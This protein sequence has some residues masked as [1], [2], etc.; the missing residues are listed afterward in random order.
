[1]QYSSNQSQVWYARTEDGWIIIPNAK[2]VKLVGY[3]GH[4]IFFICR[5][6]AL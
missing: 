5:P 4:E 2:R 6:K 3:E 1:M